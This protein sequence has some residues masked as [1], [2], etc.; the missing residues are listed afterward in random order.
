MGLNLKDEK[1]GGTF[2]PIPSGRY[3]VV[4]SDAALVKTLE[5][6]DMINI[7]YTV[8]DGDQEKRKFFDRAVI[9]PTSLWKLKTLL[10]LAESDLA[11]SSDAELEDI[12]SALKDVNMSVYVEVTKNE[13]GNA[14][15]QCSGWQKSTFSGSKTKTFKA[16]TQ[17]TSTKKVNVLE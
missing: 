2:E 13:D 15:Y 10:T 7:T 9:A 3:N 14:R 17:N 16:S 11:E 1:G 12:V 4:V 8:V 5:G 6:K